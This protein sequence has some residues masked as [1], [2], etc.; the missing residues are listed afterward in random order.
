M[1][2]S[3][4]HHPEEEAYIGK[5]KRRDGEDDEVCEE[6]RSTKRLATWRDHPVCAAA[7]AGDEQNLRKLVLQD[8]GNLEPVRLFEDRNPAHIAAMYGNASCLPILKEV[9]CNMDLKDRHGYTPAMLAAINRHSACLKVLQDMGCDLNQKD[10]VGRTA[11]HY[12]AEDGSCGYDRRIPCLWVL[13]GCDFTVQDKYRLTPAQL[14]QCSSRP[15]RVQFCTPPGD[16]DALLKSCGILFRCEP[17]D[18]ATRHAKC[19]DVLLKS[20]GTLFQC[21]P[22]IGAASMTFVQKS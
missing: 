8:A 11:A 1:S 13:T 3:E 7:F 21:E 19:T 15:N 20:C 14:L 9:G 12:A 2:D 17:N 4:H 22:T 5:R 10:H 16:G 18:A 6:C